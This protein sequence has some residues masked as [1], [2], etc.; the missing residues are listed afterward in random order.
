MIKLWEENTPGFD[1]AIG[2]IEPN[3]TPFLV[4]D[5]QAHGA[6]IV[7]PGGGYCGKADYEGAPI[8]RFLNS[9]GISAFVLD[10]R[11]SPYQHPYPLLDA[12]RAIR[13]ARYHAKAMA[14]K[15]DKIGMLGFSAGGHLSATAGTHFDAGSPDAKDPV[16]RMSC[17][18]D[19]LVLC[20]PVVTFGEFRHD[21]S[22]VALI[23]ENPTEAL[24]QSL[25]NETQVTAQTPPAFLWHTANDQAVPVE[26]S[27]LFAAAL[28]KHKVPFELHV[29]PDGPHGLSLGEG[30]PAVYTWPGMCATWLKNLGF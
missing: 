2:Q 29:Y 4:A 16:E 10:Y 9:V 18:P 12:Q 6:V 26:N 13:V 28:S 3:L 15:A 8:A 17:R 19:A 21:G 27:L 5:S 25:S 22:K 1:P 11:V 23:G 30:H 7:C 24:R 20:Y 14:I